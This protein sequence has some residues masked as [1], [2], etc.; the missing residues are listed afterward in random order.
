[1]VKTGGIAHCFG[2]LQKFVR[3]EP[4]KQRTVEA[5]EIATSMGE[6]F[7]WSGHFFGM[8]VPGFAKDKL[9]RSCLRV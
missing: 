3:R 9:A 8:Q 7:A 6:R 1:M 5:R 2:K 4:L